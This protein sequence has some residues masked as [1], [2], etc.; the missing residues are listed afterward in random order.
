M[1]NLKK[2]TLIAAGPWLVALG[3]F[4]TYFTDLGPFWLL[5]ILGMACYS[6]G[7][8]FS[9]FSEGAKGDWRE[10]EALRP[11]HLRNLT[12]G[13]NS[14]PS[15]AVALVWTPIAALAVGFV[16]LVAASLLHGG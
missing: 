5:V 1:S 11:A 13:S 3:A 2:L 8:R 12:A 16:A 15:L 9:E 4:A 14:N 7:Q 6:Y 10:F